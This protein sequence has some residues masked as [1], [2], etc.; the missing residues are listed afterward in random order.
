MAGKLLMS[1]EH[2]LVQEAVMAGKK[3]L[4]STL[5]KPTQIKDAENIVYLTE[6]IMLSR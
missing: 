3:S 4:T 5:R 6:L 2:R 1:I